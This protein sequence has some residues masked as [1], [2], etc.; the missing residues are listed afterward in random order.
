MLYPGYNV[1]RNVSGPAVLFEPIADRQAAGDAQIDIAWTGDYAA[2]FIDI[3]N[4]RPATDTVTLFMRTSSDGGATFDSATSNY[5]FRL[6]GFFGSQTTNFGLA[7]AIHMSAG[8]VGNAANENCHCSMILLHPFDTAEFTQV[9]GHGGMANNAGAPAT[10]QLYGRRE[11]AARVDAV[12]FFFAAGNI[13]EGRF[14]AT[15]LWR[16]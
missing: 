5:Q 4:A 12:R 10:T 1:A 3:F 11:A 14:T 13:A 15:G 8:N 16:G 9:I 2:V 7:T 6:N